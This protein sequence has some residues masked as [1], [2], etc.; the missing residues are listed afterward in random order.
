MV[1]VTS[2]IITV[3]F[4]IILIL[5]VNISINSITIRVTRIIVII[6]RINGKRATLAERRKVLEESLLVGGCL[7]TKER[8]P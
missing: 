6:T 3:V 7:L 5:V 2:I 1:I 4:L 8:W